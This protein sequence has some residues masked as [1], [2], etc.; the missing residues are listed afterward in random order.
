[1]AF[2]VGGIPEVIRDGE[3]GFLHDFADVEAMAADPSV[4]DPSVV[5]E[6]LLRAGATW[7]W[8]V[9]WDGVGA[10]KQA[11]DLLRARSRLP[12]NEVVRVAEPVQK[13]LMKIQIKNGRL[14]DPANNVDAKRDLGDRQRNESDRWRGNWRRSNGQQC[15]A[16]KAY[17]QVRKTGRSKAHGRL[18]DRE[19]AQ[20]GRPQRPYYTA[21]RPNSRDVGRLQMFAGL[22]INIPVFGCAAKN[23]GIQSSRF[24]E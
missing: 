22:L 2:R 8:E 6:H 11:L 17:H 4:A 1:V 14:I 7:Q 13:V 12:A 24:P 16:R 18:P 5:S 9:R 20:S 19:L 15:Q 3:T 10:R 21:L 23:T